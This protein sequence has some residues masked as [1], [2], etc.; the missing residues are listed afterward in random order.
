[1]S[2]SKWILE[3]HE[4]PWPYIVIDNF[5]DDEMWEYITE[6]LVRNPKKY[7]S[8]YK[9][10][11]SNGYEKKSE[12][13]IAHGLDQNSTYGLLYGDDGRLVERGQRRS[14]E[15][16]D[17]PHISDYYLKHVGEDFMKEHFKTWR[18]YSDSSVLSTYIA[19]KYNHLQ[20]GPCSIHDELWDKV[21]SVATYIS[22]L[23]NTG[24]IVYDKDK[25]FKHVITWK[26]NRA[27]AFPGINN[28]TWHDFMQTE[29]TPERITLDFFLMRPVSEMNLPMYSKD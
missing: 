16:H 11:F 10:K 23:H 6:N 22:P 14:Y 4:E 2:H 12:N 5:Y 19:L 8:K 15:P 28:V 9:D 7:F 29:K 26:P 27:V 3:K 25:V 1:M 17:D 18:S 20:Y 13:N 24:T 21:F